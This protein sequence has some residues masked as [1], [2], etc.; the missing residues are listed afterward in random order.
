GAV[1]LGVPPE[2]RELLELGLWDCPLR[3]RAREGSDVLE[4][5]ERAQHLAPGIAI[6]A[7]REGLADANVGERLHVVVD[8]D[9]ELDDERRV[10]DDDLV[11]E[12]LA[13]AL[14]LGVGQVAELDIGAAGPDGGRANGRLRADEEL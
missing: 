11:A 8:R 7:Q 14:H 9:A 13:D 5:R 2:A 12:L 1:L 3:A 4:A 10:L 6:D